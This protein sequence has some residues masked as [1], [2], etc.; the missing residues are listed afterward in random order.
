[1]L[2]NFAFSTVSF[3]TM[4]PRNSV[5]QSGPKIFLSGFLYRSAKVF[6]IYSSLSLD[7]LNVLPFSS[8]ISP[9]VASF[10]LLFTSP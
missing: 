4:S 7:F 5:I 1:M 3:S 10:A 8:V 9:K 6:R 2:F